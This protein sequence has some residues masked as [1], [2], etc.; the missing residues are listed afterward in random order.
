[1]ATYLELCQDV[2]RESGTFPNIGDPQTVVN[3]SGRL[4]RLVNWVNDAWREVQREQ[5]HWRWMLYDHTGNTVATVQSYNGADLGVSS[6]FGRWMPFDNGHEC[7][8]SV[9]DTAIGR[10]DEGYLRFVE[11]TDFRRIYMSR[12]NAEETGKPRVCTLAPDGK[13][14]VYPIPDKAYKL[15]CQYRRSFQD[16]VANTDVPEMPEDFHDAIKWKALVYLGMFD[17]ATE[18]K[19]EWQSK[20]VRVMGHLRADQ[21]PSMSM[22]GALG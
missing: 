19:P 9:W 21:L 15:R 5:K 3:Q 2:A 17:E 8:V 12:G 20:Y 1:M 11:W 7:E 4:L 16:L 18:Q 10:S 13:L 22:Q 6:R 14:T